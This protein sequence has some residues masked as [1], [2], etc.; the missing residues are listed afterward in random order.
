MG[1][2][3]HLGHG[4]GLSIRTLGLTIGEENHLLSSGELPSHL[5]TG[6]T[7]VGGIHSHTI[8]DPQHTH[9]Q[10]TINDDFNGNGTNPPGFAK[11]S[12]IASRTWDNINASSTGITINNSSN[13]SHTFT[14]GNTGGGGTHNN[15]QPTAFIGNVF[16]FG[17]KVMSTQ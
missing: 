10:T 15:M 9:T 14:T 2:L 12:D 5:H 4:Q 13:H 17:G 8:N 6:T 16:I 7:D 11:D 1:G 3:P